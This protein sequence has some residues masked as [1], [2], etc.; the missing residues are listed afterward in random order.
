VNEV[1]SPLFALDAADVEDD[2]NVVRLAERPSS[3][4]TISRPKPLG[5]DAVS[6]D[7][8]AIRRDP[9]RHRGVGQWLAD[10]DHP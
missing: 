6:H 2:A 1:Q 3:L 9:Q 7:V 10:R 5:V 8:D 4:A